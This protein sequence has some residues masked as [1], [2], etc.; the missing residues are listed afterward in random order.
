[1]KSFLAVFLITLSFIQF[2]DSVASEK[3]GLEDK[4]VKES[5][6][7]SDLLLES[8][9]REEETSFLD[10]IKMIS[11]QRTS[12]S[13]Y[14]GNSGFL[15]TSSM[16]LGIDVLLGN[17]F[18]LSG[19][20]IRE[21]VITDNYGT[22]LSYDYWS[23]SASGYAHGGRFS[24]KWSQPMTLVK[25]YGFDVGVMVTHVRGS[26]DSD[27]GRANSPASQYRS[28][29]FGPFITG[30]ILIAGKYVLSGSFAY[31]QNRFFVRQDGV[32]EVSLPLN[33]SDNLGQARAIVSLGYLL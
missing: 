23:D 13:E 20:V 30:N 12:N 17:N 9:V 32:P 8:L 16:G 21:E 33:I 29:A 6:S 1:M 2:G 7:V 28:T 18:F 19:H 3:I 22:S 14:F 15:A 27:S 26:L 24:L 10:R 25:N 31:E 11:I 4:Q 5:D